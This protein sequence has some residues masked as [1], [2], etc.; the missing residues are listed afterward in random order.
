MTDQPLDGTLLLPFDSADPEFARG[1][2]C[3]RLWAL[4]RAEPDAEVEEYVHAA[5]AEML[6]RMAEA[7]DRHVQT[8]DVDDVW[9]IATFTAAVPVDS[10]SG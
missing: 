8:E 1:F 7:T 9:V 5:N 2:E 3:G 10:P 6:L 4:L